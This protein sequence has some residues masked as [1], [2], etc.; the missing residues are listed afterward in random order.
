MMFILRIYT[1]NNISINYIAVLTI[2]IMLYITS[3][4]LIYLITSLYI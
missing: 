4:V 3:L 2:I 1:L